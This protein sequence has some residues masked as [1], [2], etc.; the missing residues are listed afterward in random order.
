MSR[1]TDI[2]VL[3]VPQLESCRQ[4]RSW[5]DD[6]GTL[7]MTTTNIFGFHV[8]IPRWIIIIISSMQNI[9]LAV[10]LTR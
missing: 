8:Y 1:V 5:Q 7:T 3:L 6:I 10:H 2:S 4:F 9:D